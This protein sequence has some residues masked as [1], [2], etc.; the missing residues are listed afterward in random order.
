VL[1]GPSAEVSL[2][3]GKVLESEEGDVVGR[4]LLAVGSKGNKL[5]IWVDFGFCRTAL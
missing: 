4:G 1:A 2:I 3:Q 5:D